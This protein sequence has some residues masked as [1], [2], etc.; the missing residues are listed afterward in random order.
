MVGKLSVR[1]MRILAIIRE[2]SDSILETRRYGPK[3]GVSRIIQESRQHCEC[4]VEVDLVL[5]Q[6]SF[7]YFWKLCLK[8]ASL[9]KKINLIYIIK[10][11]GLYQNK[12]NFSLISTC[13]CK[14]L[15]LRIL[16]YFSKWPS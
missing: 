8:N 4:E 3:S 12:V 5:I 10:Q 15:Y 2:I 9:R 13:N 6:T 7:L 16:W 14:M 1:E 11:D